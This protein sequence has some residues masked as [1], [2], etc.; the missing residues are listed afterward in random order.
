MW[1]KRENI[2]RK[3]FFV[4]VCHK[5]RF[6]FAL[7]RRAVEEGN[8]SLGQRAS[9]FTYTVSLIL[10]ICVCRAAHM[11]VQGKEEENMCSWHIW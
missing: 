1:K 5:L 10:R 11:C 2:K 7:E 8:P 3:P 4:T 9:R 6:I